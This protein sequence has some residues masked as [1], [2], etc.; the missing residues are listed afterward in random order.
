MS[1]KLNFFEAMAELYAGK[2]I[3]KP[4]HW[5]DGDYIY[6]NKIDGKIRDEDNEPYEIMEGTFLETLEYEWQVF[7]DTP[8]KKNSDSIQSPVVK[9][10]PV[11]L[12]QDDI[13]NVVMLTNSTGHNRLEVITRIS[14]ESDI[15]CGDLFW[16]FGATDG[17]CYNS[18]GL[19]VGVA[20]NVRIITYIRRNGIWYKVAK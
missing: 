6:L 3:T 11:L 12:N 8:K 9:S 16:I 5:I 4:D 1:K 18:Y 19:H 20:I 14:H 7:E 15:S 13:G 2:K 10:A 17:Y